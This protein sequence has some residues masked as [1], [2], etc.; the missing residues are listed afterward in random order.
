MTYYQCKYCFAISRSYK[1][2]FLPSLLYRPAKHITQNMA[3][4]T[5]RTEVALQESLFETNTYGMS[6]KKTSMPFVT[7]DFLILCRS[8]ISGK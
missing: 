3:I 6:V 5:E 8:G 1:L 4:V 7:N 2:T